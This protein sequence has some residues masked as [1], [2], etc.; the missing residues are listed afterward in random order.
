[1][2][3]GNTNADDRVEVKHPSGKA[4]TVLDDPN[5][6]LYND[7]ALQ[8][9]DRYE[10]IRGM[11]FDHDHQLLVV[12]G[13]KN[14]PTSVEGEK[15]FPNNLYLYNAQSEKESLLYGEPYF[16]HNAQYSPDQTYIYYVRGMEETGTGFIMDRDGKKRVQ[17]SDQGAIHIF[18]GKWMND[19]EVLYTTFLGDIYLADVNGNKRLLVQTGKA[20]I[21]NPAFIGSQVYYTTVDHKLMVYDLKTK[22]TETLKNHV[23]RLIPSPDQKEFAMVLRSGENKMALVLTNLSGDQ[24]AKLTEGN[25]VLGTSWS[26]DQTKLAYTVHSATRGQ[27]G[28][29]V[30]DMK[31]LKSTQLSADIQTVS[32]PI[33][34][35]RSSKKIL[36]SSMKPV[37]DE[38]AMFITYVFTLK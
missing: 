26:P 38:R 21:S 18:S 13:N 2:G 34:W 10:N 3:G 19:R 23:I 5:K 35:N 29:F 9:I 4:I 28:L 7:L 11:D 16:H 20:G 31:T 14:Q 17:V 8:K 12:K 15:T 30:T 36:A 33:R 6:F 27:Q 32:D 22:K 1:M 37:E 25:E 24:R